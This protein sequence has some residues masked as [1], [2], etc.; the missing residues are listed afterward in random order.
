MIHTSN[1]CC[2]LALTL[3]TNQ[4]S[5]HQSS[6]KSLSRCLY[7]FRSKLRDLFTFKT[8]L[9]NRIFFS[10]LRIVAAYLALISPNNTINKVFLE[11]SEHN[12]NSYTDDFHCHGTMWQSRFYWGDRVKFLFCIASNSFLVWPEFLQFQ[13]DQYSSYFPRAQNKNTAHITC[14][15]LRK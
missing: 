12:R 1:F 6:H 11:H 4:A 10:F 8:C 15:S 9:S 7:I 5:K 2:C 3:T 13:L 14:Q